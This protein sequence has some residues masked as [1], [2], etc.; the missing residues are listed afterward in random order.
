MDDKQSL[1][2]RIDDTGQTLA[3][4]YERIGIKDPSIPDGDVVAAFQATYSQETL[5]SGT[6][7]LWLV[8]A[9]QVISH[10]RQSRLLEFILTIVPYLTTDNVR[11][12]AK[13]PPSS[14][15]AGSSANI[16]NKQPIHGS[17]RTNIT[18]GEGAF[19]PPNATVAI[20]MLASSQS[21]NGELNIAPTS[22]PLEST[23]SAVDD[24]MSIYSEEASST[25]AP[26]REESSV[27]S[28]FDEPIEGKYWDGM[29]WRCEE[30]IEE[31]VDGKCPNGHIISSCRLCGYDVEAGNCTF[32]RNEDESIVEDADMVWDDGDEIW[33]CTTCLWEIEANSEDEGQCHCRIDPDEPLQPFPMTTPTGRIELLYYP[34]YE[35]ADSD[36]SGPESVDSEPDVVEM[37][38]SLKT[39]DP[40]TPGCQP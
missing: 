24:D 22:S 28:D 32:K 2:L 39:M 11:I 37:N 33:R 27:D 35:P 13:A 19:D 20:A 7:Q 4:A 5:V 3:E 23:T 34:N 9:L 26:S 12:L 6:K 17:N 18:D 38:R 8:K 40:S 21:S 25:G 15:S 29:S 1:P 16:N 36:S 31:I 14:P 10:H 30:C